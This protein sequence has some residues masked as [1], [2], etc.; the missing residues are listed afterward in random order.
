MILSTITI[1][2]TISNIVVFLTGFL[3]LNFVTA[4]SFFKIMISESPTRFPL[5]DHMNIPKQG[6]FE[7]EKNQV[8]TPQI[9]INENEKMLDQISESPIRSSSGDPVNELKEESWENEKTSAPVLSGI[10]LKT[11]QIWTHAFFPIIQEV[12]VTDGMTVENF[13]HKLKYAMDNPDYPQLN[14]LRD[15]VWELRQKSIIAK[16]KVNKLC[17]DLAVVNSIEIEPNATIDFDVIL[18]QKL[19][20][21]D[22]FHGE[23]W[24]LR[25]NGSFINPNSNA[26]NFWELMNMGWKPKN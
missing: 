10:D 4:I 15:D 11:G 3:L 26:I 17:R 13:I 12:Q 25:R 2:V 22:L 16:E 21:L 1:D 19:L 20:W 18:I 23:I 14:E 8:E 6:T 7:N 5:W 9:P 24:N